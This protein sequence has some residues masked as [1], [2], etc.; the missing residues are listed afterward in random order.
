[1]NLFAIESSFA[2]LDAMLEESQGVLTP[3]IESYLETI[4]AFAI[5][6]IFDLQALREQCQAFAKVAKEKA[7]E[8]AAKAKALERR[9]EM[10]KSWQIRA[11][12]AAGQKSMTNGVYKITLVQNPLKIEVVDENAVPSSY[13]V[14]EV[15]MSLADYEKIKSMV[16][17]K[18]V[19][20]AVD[21]KSI[22]DL[23]KAAGV[24][25]SGVE[26]RRDDNVRVS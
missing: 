15:K 3:E 2:V 6:K 20:V 25:V 8:Y 7:D 24:E 12:S 22:G 17:V 4:Q 1:M 16:E 10:F 21:K 9:D 18:S 11:L 26:Y 19:K 13:Q 23:Y 14:A 5:H